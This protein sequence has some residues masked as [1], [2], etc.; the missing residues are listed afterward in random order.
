ME[1]GYWISRLILLNLLLLFLI[2]ELCESPVRWNSLRG[3]NLTQVHL[4]DRDVRGVFEE[5]LNLKH[6][7]LLALS[8]LLLS[9]HWGHLWLY[10]K[11][12]FI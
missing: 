2:H 3:F 8:V 7:N 12:A 5:I 1:L 6:L 9:L 11:R 4:L 10:A